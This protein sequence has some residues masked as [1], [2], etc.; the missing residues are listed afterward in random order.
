[1]IADLHVWI[2]EAMQQLGTTAELQPAEE[3]INIRFHKAHLPCGLN[4]LDTLVCDGKRVRQGR[5]TT[6]CQPNSRDAFFV[7]GIKQE[8]TP[9]GNYMYH[10]Y[11]TAI[12]DLNWDSDH[13][14][15]MEGVNA[16]VTSLPDGLARIYFQK[17]PTD[18]DGFP[19]VPDIG[20]Y[21]MAIYY[22][23]RGTMIGAGY[24]DNVFSYDQ[25]M[26]PGGY[27]ETEAG[28]AKEEI[29][30]PSVNEMDQKVYNWLNAIPPVTDH[31]I[32][33]QS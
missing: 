13:W 5:N 15:E 26:G 8:N 16:I 4:T 2:A 28:R 23:V 27:W 20:S 25:L 6:V 33:F 3:N 32:K 22:F 11:A 10:S 18:K 31:Y 12:A 19:L 29:T 7:T 17:F 14:W 1:M 24:K 9:S 30:Y 21:K